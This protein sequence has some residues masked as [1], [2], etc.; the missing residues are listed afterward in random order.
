MTERPILFSGPMVKAILASRKTQTRRLVKPPPEWTEPGTAWTSGFLGDGSRAGVSWRAHHEEYPE[1]GSLLYRCP[2]GEPGDHLWVRET[3]RL[4]SNQEF[5]EPGH[6]PPHADGRP[7]RRHEEGWWEQPHYR[8]TDP[9]PE[10]DD[11]QGDG[12]GCRWTPSIYMPRW[13]SRITLEVLQ[14][15]IERLRDISESDAAAE[16]AQHFPDIPS[17]HPYPRSAHR[18]SMESPTNTDQCLGSARMAFANF[19][20]QLRGR[21]SWDDNPWVWAVTFQRKK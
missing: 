16:G 6:E 18:W 13:A 3:F 1:E 17:S 9:A 5:L 15:R 8:A 12:P 4:E 19:W 14:V 11:G 7:V 2:F 20:I 10:L 21:D